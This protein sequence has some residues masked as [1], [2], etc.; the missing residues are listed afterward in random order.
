MTPSQRADLLASIEE[1]AARLT[2][3]VANLL[4]MSRI[5]AGALKPR[6][7]FVD[8][9]EVVRAAVERARKAF[10]GQSIVTSVARDL[11][12]VRGDSNLLEQVLFNLPDNAQKYGGG[13][14]VRVHARRLGG[15]VQISVTDEGDGVKS[16]D[17]ERIFEKF[18]Q[19]G[20]TDGRKAGT[21]SRQD[22]KRSGRADDHPH[23]G[24]DRLSVQRGVGHLKNERTASLS[25]SPVPYIANKG[26][27][28]TLLVVHSMHLCGVDGISNR[29]LVNRP[30][31]ATALGNM[32]WPVHAGS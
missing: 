24:G 6:R 17:I 11:P 19:G 8:V 20:R 18:Y 27:L 9:A 29:R 4:D 22:R 16:A 25:D 26:S 3:F 32:V 10:P 1:E 30:T 2:R 31:A 13:A 23:G 14:E 21:P 15:N 28:K 12:M 5:E 7:D